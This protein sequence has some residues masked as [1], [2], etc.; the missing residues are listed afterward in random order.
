MA[1]KDGVQHRSRWLL[2]LLAAPVLA[3]LALTLRKLL[4]IEPGVGLY[5]LPLSAIIVSAWLG[6]RLAGL[7][8]TIVSAL[9]IAFWF[10]EAPGPARASRGEL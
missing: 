9:G 6:G 5:P 4:P 1:M 7:A 3:A 8:A 10:L 2:E